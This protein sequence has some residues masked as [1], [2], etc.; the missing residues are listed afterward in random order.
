MAPVFLVCVA[1]ASRALLVNKAV[2]YFLLPAWHAIFPPRAARRKKRRRGPFVSARM[3]FLICASACS[4][5]C[6][7]SG[8][9]VLA[10]GGKV[11]QPPP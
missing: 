8:V 6:L 11:V 9:D 10:C 7:G 2:L 3:C 4:H 1:A 5:V